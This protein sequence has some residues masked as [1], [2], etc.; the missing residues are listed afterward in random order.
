MTDLDMKLNMIEMAITS[1]PQI[2]AEKFLGEITEMAKL[3]LHQAANV[4][5]EPASYDYEM[6]GW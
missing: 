1:M 2:E 6:A 5:V 4:N 3:R